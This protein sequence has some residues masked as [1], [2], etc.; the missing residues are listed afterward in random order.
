M[1]WI[2]GAYHYVHHRTFV[3][4]LF[5]PVLFVLKVLGYSSLIPF[6]MMLV[7]ILPAVCLDIEC[8]SNSVLL[9]A[10]EINFITS[11]R[12]KKCSFFPAVAE[13]QKAFCIIKVSWK[14]Y[15]WLRSLKKDTQTWENVAVSYKSFYELIKNYSC[16][17]NYLIYKSNALP[18]MF[19]LDSSVLQ[20]V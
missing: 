20:K 9:T 5:L 8:T 4:I 2:K 12:K 7:H 13:I 1:N 10:Y 17:F 19:K 14:C 18:L 15:L 11:S 3:K 16:N 6:S